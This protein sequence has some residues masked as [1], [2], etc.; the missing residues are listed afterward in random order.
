MHPPP[1]ESLLGLEEALDGL[2]LDPETLRMMG[3]GN[4]A[5][6]TLMGDRNGGGK[7]GLY[8]ALA[9]LKEAE[10]RAQCAAGLLEE[11]GE[12]SPVAGQVFDI[13]L[14]RY[15]SLRDGL[16][17]SPEVSSSSSTPLPARKTG[18]ESDTGVSL[19]TEKN[20][21]AAAET[22]NAKA[23]D[24]TLTGALSESIGEESH[25]VMAAVVVLAE[26]L[27]ARVF[28]TGDQMLSCIRLVLEHE[29]PTA[30]NGGG[31]GG[32]S[33]DDGGSAIGEVSGHSVGFV[34]HG[35][36]SAKHTKNEHLP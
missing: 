14:R 15:L 5:S 11:L 26:K 13:L 27:G 18:D 33:G 3:I 16:V 6:G 22:T 19:S 1:D 28:G 17:V 29:R 2:G 7:G 31:A 25:A 8:D 4:E 34:S 20:T 10:G 24:A 9:G 23:S 21:K 12:E 30:G 36:E 32:G 35:A